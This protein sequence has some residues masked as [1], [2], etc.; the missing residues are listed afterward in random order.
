MTMWPAAI[1]TPD[2]TLINPTTGVA[3]QTA[4]EWRDLQ[5][6]VLANNR[7]RLPKLQWPEPWLSLEVPTVYINYGRWMVR[8]ACGDRPLVHPGWSLALCLGCGAIYER[9]QMPEDADAIARVLCARPEI[10]Q[11]NWA[12]PETLEHLISE[13]IAHGDRAV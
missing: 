12:P 4:Q 3:V 11:R 9:L 7:R 1:M 5:R 13:N 6:W 10:G 2:Y 8:C